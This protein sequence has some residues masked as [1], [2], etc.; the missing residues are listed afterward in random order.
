[1]ILPE[2]I[3]NLLQADS[4]KHAYKTKE[5]IYSYE[6]YFHGMEIIW[7]GIRLNIDNLFGLI[8]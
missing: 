2:P 4:V 8:P 1:M 7:N 3:I 5:Y 6:Q